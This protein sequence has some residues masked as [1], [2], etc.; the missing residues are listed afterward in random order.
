MALTRDT[1]RPIKGAKT[2]SF[3]V[4]N[5]LTVFT[6]SYVA[7]NEAGFLRVATFAA[8]EK[9]LGRLLPTPNPNALGTTPLVGDTAAAVPIE[10]TVALEGEVLLQ[11]AVTGVTAIANLGD[12]VYATDDDVLTLTRPARG[13]PFGVVIR[14]HTGTTVDVL[15]F[16]FETLAAIS[17]GGNGAEL[18]NFGSFDCDTI[19]AGAADIRTG[20]ALPPYRGRILSLFAMI[21]VAPAGGGGTAAI[22]LELDGVNVTG[23]VLTIATGN[24]KGARVN[25]TAITAANTFSESSVLDIEVAAGNV[26]MTAGRFDLFAITERLLGV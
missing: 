20:M 6:G 10:G 4:G 16:G 25:A 12:M 18:V 8:G 13:L 9:L 22:N 2:Y 26:D 14:F 15:R 7:L 17:M 24:A 23:G 11:V 3:Q 21:D 19:P 5:T 1:Q